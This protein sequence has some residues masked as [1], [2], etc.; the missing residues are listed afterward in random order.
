MSDQFRFL[1]VRLLPK[2]AISRLAGHFAKSPVSRFLIPFYARFFQ[3]D[4]EEAEKPIGEYQSLT[5]F[6]TRRLRAG[7]RPVAAGEDILTAPVDGVVSQFGLIQEGT[8]LQ[9]KGVTYS[10][11]QLLGDAR[12][13]ESYEGGMYLTIYLS[14]RDYHRIHTCLKGTVSGYSYIPGS[15]YPVNPL[16]VRNVPGLFARNER[17][18]TYLTSPFGEYAIVKVGATIVGSVQVVYDKKLSTNV[19]NGQPAHETVNGPLLEKG[20]ELGLFRFGS[21]VVCLFQPGMA[22]LDPL[23]E[24]QFVRMGERIGEVPVK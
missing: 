22:K 11:E 9:A 16:G 23:Q 19:R 15:L 24:G 6:F 8:L 10:L 3:V 5:E 13:A 1:L 21:T 4:L 18:T 14:P 7:A 20:D 2:K 12:K 17:L